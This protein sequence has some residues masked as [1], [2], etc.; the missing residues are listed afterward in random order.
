M[1]KY[2]FLFVVLSVLV[3]SVSAFAADGEWTAWEA[4]LSGAAEIK[5]TFAD[6]FLENEGVKA[7]LGEVTEDA[8]SGN[9]PGSPDDPAD[10]EADPDKETETE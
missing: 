9:E 1:K 5:C 7:V 2:S 8:V 6:P 10:P 3:L 4:D